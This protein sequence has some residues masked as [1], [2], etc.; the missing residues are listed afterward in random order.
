ILYGDEIDV[1]VFVSR[2]GRTSAIFQ[3]RVTRVSDGQLCVQST[4]VHVAMNLDTRRPVQLPEKFR[5]AFGD[6]AA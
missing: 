4:Q 6:D 2:P 5:E 1:E 3:Y